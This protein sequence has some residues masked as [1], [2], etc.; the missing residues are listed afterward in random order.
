MAELRSRHARFAC[1]CCGY[2]TLEEQAGYEICLLCWWEDDGQSDADAA[3]VRGGPNGNLSLA[4][5]RR[6]FVD[7]LTMYARGHDTRL[8]G[9]DS[10]LEVQAKRTLMAAYEEIRA[11]PT[12]SSL[13]DIVD[14]QERVLRAETE[15]KVG[16]A[17][18]LED[19][20]PEHLPNER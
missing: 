18:R 13:W 16:K 5:A 20:L 8:G 12:D 2:P 10:A 6:N 9:E 15:R 17:G 4:E 11:R 1:P 7:H 3:K 19:D 14:A